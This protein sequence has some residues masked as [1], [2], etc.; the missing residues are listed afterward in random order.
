M[1][2]A[3]AQLGEEIPRQAFSVRQFQRFNQPRIANGKEGGPR[4]NLQIN[5]TEGRTDSDERNQIPDAHVH[6]GAM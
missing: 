6:G 2:R 1:E 4:Q 3:S 5:E